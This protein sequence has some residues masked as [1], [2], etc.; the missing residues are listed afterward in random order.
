MKAPPERLGSFYLGSVYDPV[1]DVKTGVQV[2]YDARDLTTHAVCFGMTGSGKTGLCLCMLEEAALD[3]VPAIIIDPKGDITNHLLH[4]PELQPEDFQ[5]W[6]NLDDARRKG[7]TREQYSEMISETWRNGLSDWGIDGERVRRLSE[8][9]DYTIYTPGSTSGVPV[10]ILSSLKAPKVADTE[11]MNDL[12]IGTVAALFELAHINEDPVRS[13][14]GILLSSILEHNWRN[15]RDVSLEDLIMSIQKPPFTKLGVFD[16]ETFYPAGKRLELAMS[17]NSLLASP[18]FQEWLSGESM[19]V[20]DLLYTGDGKPRHSIFYLAHLNDEEK[21]FFVTLLLEK[22]SGWIMQQQGT[23]S[24]RAILYFDEVYGFMPPVAKPPSKT[25]LLRLLK[26]ARA[27]GLG[28][29]LVT[30]NTVDIDYKGLS[31]TGTWFIGKLQTKRDKDRILEGLKSIEGG[32][33]DILDYDD[34]ISGLKGRVFLMHNVHEPGPVVFHTRW[35]MNYLRG[36]LTRPQIQ[37]LM[38]EKKSMVSASPKASAVEAPGQAQRQPP[39]LDPDIPVMY[40]RGA[41]GSS[42]ERLVWREI[43]NTRINEMETV[44]K[45]RV[46]A[47]YTLRFV[48]AKREIDTMQE[49]Y[50]MLPE[51]DE[52]GLIDWTDMEEVP[53]DIVTGRAPSMDGLF[54]D[55]PG[56]INS[57]KELKKLGDEISDHLY[58][59]SSYPIHV[60]EDL[61]I[62]QEQG[63]SRKQ[64]LLRLKQAARERRD[65]EVNKLKAKYEK[66]LDKLETRLDKLNRDLDGDKSE[67]GARKRE[68]VVGIGETMLGFFMGSRRTTGASTAMRRRRMTTR[69][70]NEIADTKDEIKAT[71]ED[72]D[73]VEQELREQVDEITARWDMVDE[74]ITEFKVKP[75]R[76]DVDVKEVAIAWAPHIH[77]KF[78]MQGLET[79]RTLKAYSPLTPD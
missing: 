79:S 14:E 35:A 11:A 21:M 10:N 1:N 75:R 49:H 16:L 57:E 52:R 53:S 65:E 70:K 76:K 28:V 39:V 46:L 69:I 43:G 71:Q 13:K 27:F 36:P 4:F 45:P 50:G 9:V 15:Q 29:V 44:Y 24:L 73:E 30:Q 63:E 25:P 77:V 56:H 51:P 8:A 18:N 68:E 61:E 66:Q 37:Q 48:N 7:M 74:G 78:T 32:L 31:N 17:L 54:L 3:K 40:I 2:N 26:Q 19:D 41:E 20:P 55:L 38:A 34:L 33:E 67:Y 62:Y 22:I 6:V 59:N 42:L 72:Y 58:Y 60:H 5:P 23:T 47:R 64:F 12:I